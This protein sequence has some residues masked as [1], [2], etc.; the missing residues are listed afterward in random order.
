MVEHTP[1]FHQL[2]GALAASQ[3]SVVSR[4]TLKSSNVRQQFLGVHRNWSGSNPRRDKS[5]VMPIQL[6]GLIESQG[7][8]T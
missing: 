6:L 4:G 1:Y 8:C 5:S 2:V 7:L 3:S